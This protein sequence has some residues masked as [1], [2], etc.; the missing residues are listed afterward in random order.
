MKLLDI[1]KFKEVYYMKKC[2]N[3]LFIFMLISQTMFTSVVFGTVVDAEGSK[4]NIKTDLSYEDNEGNSVDHEEYEGDISVVVESSVE[5][6]DI[7]EIEAEYKEAIELSIPEQ[8]QLEEG[9]SDSLVS[10]ETEVAEYNASLNGIVEVEFNE[11]FEVLELEA[12]EGTFT[13]RGEIEA[14]EE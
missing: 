2:L 12:L 9:Q 6:K 4:K 5:N 1:L 7:E 8:I 10:G 11:E 3:I 13:L 14:D